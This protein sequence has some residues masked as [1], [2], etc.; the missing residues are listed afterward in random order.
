MK[1]KVAKRIRKAI[2]LQEGDRSQAHVYKMLKEQYLETPSNK[3]QEF[4][5]NLERNF[6]A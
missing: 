5:E 2:N 3:R 6:N 4:L 1:N